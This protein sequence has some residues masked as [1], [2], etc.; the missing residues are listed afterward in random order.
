MMKHALILMTT[1]ALA[2]CGGTQDAAYLIDG[3]Q[4]SLTLTRQQAFIGGD[5]ATELVVARFPPCQRRHPLKELVGDKVKMDVYRTDPG[6]FILNAGKRWYVT[7]TATCR[8][9]QFK[10]P[11]PEP[12]ELIGTFQFVEGKLDYKNKEEK[13]PAAGAASPGAVSPAPTSAR[14]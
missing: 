5:W 7:E 13:K 8:L 3:S 11:P 6:V 1:L 9:E 2:A 4:H 12:G 14:P 10:T